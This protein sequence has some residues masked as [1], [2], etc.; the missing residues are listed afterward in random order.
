M[1]F[2][3]TRKEINRFHLD[4]EVIECL[5][6]NLPFPDSNFGLRDARPVFLL[7]LKS[8]EEH[9]LVAVANHI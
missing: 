8:V 6:V 7:L 1:S 5:Q 3:P 4:K 9:L 2:D